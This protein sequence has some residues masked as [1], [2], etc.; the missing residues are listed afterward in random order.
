[1]TNGKS[2]DPMQVGQETDASWWR[3]P[4]PLEMLPIRGT[5]HNTRRERN[6]IRR[7]LSMELN[8]T[9]YPQKINPKFVCSLDICCPSPHVES[10]PWHDPVLGLSPCFEQA[11]WSSR[12]AAF[13]LVGRPATGS[14]SSAWAWGSVFGRVPRVP[15]PGP[16]WVSSLSCSDDPPLV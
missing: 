3:W 5:M 14:R 6:P 1:M 11:L 4:P 12:L 8:D 2:I 9:L 7:N 13:Q 10:N 16:D 15:L